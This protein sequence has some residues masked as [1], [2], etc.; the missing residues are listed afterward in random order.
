MSLDKQAV[1]FADLDEE[2]LPIALVELNKKY[3]IK[4]V[5]KVFKGVGD[6]QGDVSGF[7]T[8][9]P[10]RAAHVKPEAEEVDL[11]RTHKLVFEDAHVS[12][13]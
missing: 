11:S 4:E 12:I 3:P 2:T 8:K 13:A 9:F 7:K 6:P 5:E 1:S 10:N